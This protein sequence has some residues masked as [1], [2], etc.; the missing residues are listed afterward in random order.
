MVGQRV[1]MV[2]RKADGKVAYWDAWR[3]VQKVL[4]VAMKVD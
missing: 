1:L 2:V 4:T 3:V